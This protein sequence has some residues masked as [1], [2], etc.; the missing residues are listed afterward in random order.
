MSHALII[1]PTIK[2]SNFTC[3]FKIYQS[4]LISYLTDDGRWKDGFIVRPAVY[5][6]NYFKIIPRHFRINIIIRL[7][8]EQ[9]FV[10]I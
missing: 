5:A 9:M 7:I 3:S 10:I 6:I 2:F 1:N 4:K 8:G